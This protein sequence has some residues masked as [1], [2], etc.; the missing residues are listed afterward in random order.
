MSFLGKTLLVCAL[1]HSAFQGKIGLL[2]QVF[3]DFLLL[4]SVRGQ[5]QTSGGPLAEGR[6]PRGVTPH[7]RSEAARRS[8]PTF[9]ARGGSWEE[10][11]HAQRT[12]AVQVQEGLEEL[13]HVE[14]QE[15][16][17]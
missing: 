6:R 7:P 12:V 11:P 14:G 8:H 5:G 10:P 3:L 1:L 2:L 17:P 13:S 15:G 9:K 4:H 16:Q